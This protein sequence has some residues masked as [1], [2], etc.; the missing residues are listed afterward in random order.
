MDDPV[1]HALG[2]VRN[3]AALAERLATR[4]IVVRSLHCDWSAFGSWTLD[5][6]RGDAEAKRSP[7]IRLHAFDET[8][9]EVC[10][11]IWDG[12]E[13]QLSM[14]STPSKVSVMVNQWRYI[15]PQSCDSYE[16]ALTLAENWLY[17]R[18]GS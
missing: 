6:S 3:L 18:L 16:H 5:A 2:F 4:N 8:G 10:R 14:G 13:R 17:S 7:A 15:E 9:P 11:A 12:K 1:A